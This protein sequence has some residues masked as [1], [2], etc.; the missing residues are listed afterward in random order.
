MCECVYISN[1]ALVVRFHQY[2]R[3][4]CRFLCSKL[5]RIHRLHC[6]PRLL[7]TMAALAL[8]H[9]Y[10]YS[11]LHCDYRLSFGKSYHA[12]NNSARLKLDEHTEA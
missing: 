11:T 1:F 8:L 10:L 7:S 4:A 3:D 5:V 6:G 2:L 9:S 12:N